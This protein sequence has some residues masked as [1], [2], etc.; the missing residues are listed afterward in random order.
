MNSCPAG[1]HK[2]PAKSKGPPMVVYN[3]LDPLGRLTMFPE[4]LAAK[5][6]L[7]NAK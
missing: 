1:M 4:P 3:E 2:P 7:K 5:P 6:W